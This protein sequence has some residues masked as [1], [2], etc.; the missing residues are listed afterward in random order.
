LPTNYLLPISRKTAGSCEI[1]ANGNGTITYAVNSELKVIPVFVVT[2]N[3]NLH[4]DWTV[5]GKEAET[6]VKPGMLD[7]RMDYQE[8]GKKVSGFITGVFPGFALQRSS[9]SVSHLRSEFA[10]I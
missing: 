5:Y 3:Q 10:L 2:S 7:V 4:I 1:V 9:L 8:Q 6:I